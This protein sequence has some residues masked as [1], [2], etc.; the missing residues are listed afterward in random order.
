MQSS[1]EGSNAEQLVILRELNTAIYDLSRADLGLLAERVAGLKSRFQQ[2]R[3]FVNP[4]KRRVYFVGA[5]MWFDKVNAKDPFLYRV[6][7]SR[8]QSG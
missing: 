8:K 5:W 3:S 6:T 1:E 4:V 2:A 7:V